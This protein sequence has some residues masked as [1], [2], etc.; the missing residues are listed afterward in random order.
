MPMLHM[1]AQRHISALPQ[2]FHSPTVWSSPDGRI[3][4]IKWSPLPT[5]SC[6]GRVGDC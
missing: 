4:G 2:I 5:N 1:L 6:E 3:F